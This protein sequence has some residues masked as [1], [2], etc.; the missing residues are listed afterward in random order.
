METTK[1]QGVSG[2]ITFNNY[3]DP[4]KSVVINTINN[5]KISSLCV[6]EP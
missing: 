2:E 1:F 5:G 6:M 3:G 4:K